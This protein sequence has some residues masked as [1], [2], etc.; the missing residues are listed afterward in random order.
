MNDEFYKATFDR[1]E[2]RAIAL[3]DNPA[4]RD[5]RDEAGSSTLQVAIRN[6]MFRLASHLVNAGVDLNAQNDT[7]MTA[8]HS[9][10]VYLDKSDEAIDPADKDRLIDLLQAIVRHRPDL[11]LVRAEDECSS[12][13]LA[14]AM[15]MM[16]VVELLLDAGADVNQKSIG[17]GA[18]LRAAD[19]GHADLCRLLIDRGADVNDTDRSAQTPLLQAS[20]NGH[21]ATV[22]ALLSAGADPNIQTLSGFTALMHASYKGH[23]KIVRHLIKKGA[24]L[25]LRD[26]DGNGPIEYARGGGARD[27]LQLLE[28]HMQPDGPQTGPT[29]ETVLEAVRSG[30]ADE[31]SKA[32][33]NGADPG[34]VD[35]EGRPAVGW[36]TALGH[37]SVLQLLIDAGADA[38]ALAPDGTS[39]LEVACKLG[40]QEAAGLLIRSGANVNHAASTGST[41]LTCAVNAGSSAIV[42]WLL[43]AGAAVDQP[44]L[45]G[46]TPLLFAA[47]SGETGIAELLLQNGAAP[48]IRS[49]TGLTALMQAARADNVQMVKLL[50][51][52][53][54]DADIQDNYNATAGDMASSNA[55]MQLLQRSEMIHE[56]AE[57]R[58]ERLLEGVV[59]M[60]MEEAGVQQ[61]PARRSWWKF[62]Q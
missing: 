56:S 6:L 49:D 55:V 58:S 15:G 46:G 50:L 8:I 34:A 1:D 45:G 23:T 40:N 43:S 16:R 32:I 35:E 11:T 60:G 9:I 20:L 30:D 44:G 7:G 19:D 54:A 10:I 31:V 61:R 41:P 37:V 51:D 4:I 39:P 33:A 14:S 2:D 5:A 29:S 48:D 17:G 57:E 53:G 27:V 3:A 47:Q 42:E 52:H 36:A 28:A 22:R 18:L 12:L 62:W 21:E 25:N 26:G 24:D 13:M 59:K 38:N